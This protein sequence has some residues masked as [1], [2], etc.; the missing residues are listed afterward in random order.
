MTDASLRRSWLVSAA[1]LAL[2]AVSTVS[3]LC[4]IVVLGPSSVQRQVPERLSRSAL[5][6]GVEPLVV[7]LGSTVALGAL[8]VVSLL[9]YSYAQWRH[10]QRRRRRLESESASD[11]DLGVE[12]T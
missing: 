3:L 8:A 7:L 12:R 5:E 11:S 9:Y 4:Y 1:S 2:W 10:V 6:S